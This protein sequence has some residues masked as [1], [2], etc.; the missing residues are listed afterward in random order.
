MSYANPQAPS[1]PPGQHPPPWYTDA[2]GRHRGRLWCRKRW[3]E[4]VASHGRQAVD[5]PVGGAPVPSANRSADAVARD[6]AR[7]GVAPT[8]QGGGTL[9]TEPVLV[10]NQKAKLIEI[11]N[12]YAICD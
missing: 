2:F 5:P 1:G 9:F 3:T 6:V 10:V 4:H 7:A 11:N 8:H 12:E